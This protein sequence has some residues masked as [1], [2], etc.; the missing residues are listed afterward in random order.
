MTDIFISYSKKDQVLVEALAARLQADGYVVW[1][2]TSLL[3]GD[4]F[5]TTIDAQLEAARAVIVVWT[6]NS[7][8]SKWVIS[9][10]EHADAQGKLIPLRTAEIEAGQIPKPFNMRQTDLVDNRVAVRAALQRRGIEARYA[11]GA[12]GSLHDRFWKE[13]EAS[14]HPEDFEQYLKEFPEGEHAA[15]AR[16]KIGRLKRVL[17]AVVAQEKAAAV[18]AQIIAVPEVPVKQT[19]RGP[20]FFSTL[21]ASLLAS[22]AVGA[23]LWQGV[24][25]PGELS[26][27]AA[28]S[29]LVQSVERQSVAQK[30]ET[31]AVAAKLDK[32]LDELARPLRDDDGDWAE[33]ERLGTIAAWQEYRRRRPL[34]LHEK[35][36][37]ALIVERIDKGRLIVTLEE[38][39][40]PVVRLEPGDSGSQSLLSYD[41]QGQQIAWDLVIR[42]RKGGQKLPAQ[43]VQASTGLRVIERVDCNGATTKI[44][45]TVS[46]FCYSGLNQY[47]FQRGE[48]K[49][50]APRLGSG[51]QVAVSEFRDGGVLVVS[52]NAFLIFDAS[53]RLTQRSSASPLMA[54]ATSL[55]QGSFVAALSASDVRIVR[56]SDGHELAVM[57]VVRKGRSI[58]LATIPGGTLLAAGS[59]DGAIQIWDVS[60]LK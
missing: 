34:G 20:G 12:H 14:E 7:I 43:M 39:K 45:E 38:H 48:A 31:A 5:R 44:T 3:S 11:A 24:L 26:T 16:L 18:P 36:A 50:L 15:F 8:T 22:A 28:I 60:D 13:I 29:A 25:A 9:E 32:A 57:P 27:R 35:K 37:A 58:A 1:W 42:T 6:P 55:Q 49:M 51:S 21:A 2:D 41:S 40:A 19:S 47:Y 33:A 52:G 59:E 17:G 10:A 56:Q 54:V 23:G 53:N 46:Y 30:A 4:D